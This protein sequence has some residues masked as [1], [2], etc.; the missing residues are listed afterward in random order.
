ML[1]EISQSQTEKY[2]TRY[3]E[4]SNS[5]R[6]NRMPLPKPGE[7]GNGE[8]LITE[9]WFCQSSGHW[10]HNVNVLNTTEL[11]TKMVKMV[12]FVLCV[13]LLQ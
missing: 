13:F 7:E 12:N 8:Y 11:Y 5:L 6:Q 10:L 3:L 2:C 1:S 9:L 4:E